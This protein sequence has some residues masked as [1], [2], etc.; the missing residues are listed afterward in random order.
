M[1]SE[2]GRARLEAFLAAPAADYDPDGPKGQDPY[3]KALD[4]ALDPDY[5]GLPPVSAKA[6]ANWLS[7]GWAD[8]TEEEDTSVKD[9]LE[10]AVTDWCGGRV[11]P[12]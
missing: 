9:V 5:G 4:W 6:F 2:K 8:W 12:S 3:G 11:M 10:G 7:N 1:L